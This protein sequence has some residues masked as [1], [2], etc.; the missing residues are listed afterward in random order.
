MTGEVAKKLGIQEGARAFFEDAPAEAMTAID[1]PTLETPGELRGEFDYL[2][3]V[4]APEA[5]QTLPEPLRAIKII[6]TGEGR[7]P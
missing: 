3:Q 7:Q 2:N 6:V 5:G 4:H 1:P